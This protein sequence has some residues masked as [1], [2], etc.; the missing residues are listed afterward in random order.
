MLLER[1]EENRLQRPGDETHVGVQSL[2]DAL[3]RPGRRARGAALNA[4]DVA[5]VD[6]AARGELRLRE[7]VLLTQIDDLQRDVNL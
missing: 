6:A 1:E 3:K 7:A 2:G 4:A 5:L